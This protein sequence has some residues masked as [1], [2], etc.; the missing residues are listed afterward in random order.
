MFIYNLT[1]VKK[2]VGNSGAVWKS[3]GDIFNVIYS[4]FVLDLEKAS[5]SKEHLANVA[6]SWK[7]NSRYG[8]P[9]VVTRNISIP[10]GG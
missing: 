2:T 8:R 9:K 5:S 6:S 7:K 4:L 1:M 10:I 3:N